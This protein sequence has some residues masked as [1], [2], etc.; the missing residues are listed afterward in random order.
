MVD[1]LDELFEDTMSLL[2]NEVLE[3]ENALRRAIVDH[4]DPCKVLM[5]IRL[6]IVKNI[7][8]VLNR[9]DAD[10]NYGDVTV[11]YNNAHQAFV[12]RQYE[13]LFNDF[14]YDIGHG[15]GTGE[16]SVNGD[17]VKDGYSGAPR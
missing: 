1:R 6:D 10:A 14:H 9:D 5:A 7:S 4:K 16:G 13:G 12:N 17:P 2:D 11:A 8:C 3:I 15:K